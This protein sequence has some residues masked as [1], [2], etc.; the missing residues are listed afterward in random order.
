M[1]YDNLAVNKTWFSTSELTIHLSL[2]KN[3]RPYKLRFV[4]MTFILLIVFLRLSLSILFIIFISLSQASLRY[5]SLE[6]SQDRDEKNYMIKIT[7]VKWN[8][9]VWVLTK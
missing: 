8:E 5:S 6:K 3:S 4:V 1:I 9:Q 2:V 7:N